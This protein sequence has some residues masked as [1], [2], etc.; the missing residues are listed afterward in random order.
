[1]E[2]FGRYLRSLRGDKSLR[3]VQKHTGI[4]HTYLS[5]LERGYDPRT[6]KPRK[7][8]PDVLRKL[9]DF[10]KVDY[11]DLLLKAGHI[12]DQQLKQLKE[13]ELKMD[14]AAHALRNM[15]LGIDNRTD[16]LSIV[17]SKSGLH[18]GGKQLNKKD[19]LTIAEFLLK[20]FANTGG[21]D[22]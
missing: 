20:H 17:Y 10:Y 16:L 13:N 15:A 19:R 22:D 12:D 7:P 18:V 4:S 1:M 8:S 5:T 2:E 14:I 6:K 11:F 3:E 9:A 21:G